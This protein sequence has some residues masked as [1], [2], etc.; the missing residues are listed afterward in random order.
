MVNKGQFREDLFYRLNVVPIHVPAL[1]DH[2]EDI[3]E[4]A[5]FFADDLAL[6]Y[7]RPATKIPNSIINYLYSYDWSGNIRELRNVI[8]YMYVMQGDTLDLNLSHLPPYL[9][10]T[11]E[12]INNK[13]E[14]L[15]EPMVENIKNNDKQSQ[16]NKE[17]DNL[18]IKRHRLEY[19]TIIQVLDKTGYTLDGKK[20][21]AKMLGISIA[22]LYRRINKA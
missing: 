7:Q 16:L 15:L 1:R 22:T 14:Y 6:T 8:E 19:Q 10:E 5:Q 3:A 21:A 18:K 12:T 20:K 13:N 9:L 11:A 4:L 17:K 2:R